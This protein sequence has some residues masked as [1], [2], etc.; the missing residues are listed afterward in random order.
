MEG[1]MGRLQQQ[2]K[3]TD[4]TT[5]AVTVTGVG[6]PIVFLNGFGGYQAIWTAQIQPLVA[7]G[8]QTITFDYRGQGDS[9]GDCASNINDLA[10][11]LQQLLTNLH[12]QRPV[13]VGHSMG[14]S[15][16]WAF[17]HRYP[18]TAVR[19]WVS[20]DQSPQMVNDADW[21]YG[22]RGL[23]ATNQKDFLQIKSRLHETLHGLDGGVLRV[24][25]DAEARH[26]FNP[27]DAQRLLLSHLADDWRPTV[28]AEQS[29]AL[30][31]SARQSPYYP[32]GYAEWCQ[33]R[34]DHVRAVVIEDCGHDVMAEVPAAFNQTMRHFVQQ[35][36][37]RT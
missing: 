35:V 20:V 26:P 1:M 7:L 32:L 3:L 15:L 5:L 16:I 33:K 25:G 6:L 36:K 8:G 28:L 2:V 24:L 12:V 4:G 34:N 19:G 29:P 31:V 21:P 22:F 11:D 9:T 18:D 37:Q 23:T 10:D 27:A 14:A 30:M 13:L 17:R